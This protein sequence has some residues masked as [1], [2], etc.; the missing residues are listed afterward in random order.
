MNY[1]YLVVRHGRRWRYYKRLNKRNE[2]YFKLLHGCTAV[3]SI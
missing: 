2:N 3:K 1:W